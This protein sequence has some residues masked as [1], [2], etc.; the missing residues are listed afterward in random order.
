MNDIQN[1][2]RDLSD[3]MDGITGDYE[4]LS[5]AV[6]DGDW[7][8]ALGLAEGLNAGA[9]EYSAGTLELVQLIKARSQ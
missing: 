1:M 6:E 5:M 3:R 8:E 7:E 4:D 2:I 9:E